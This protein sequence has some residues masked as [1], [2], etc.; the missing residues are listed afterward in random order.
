M[1]LPTERSTA[2]CVCEC[3]PSKPTTRLAE[4]LAFLRQAIRRIIGAPDYETYLARHR[5]IHPE[6]PPMS[7]KEFFRFAIDRRY[8]KAGPRCC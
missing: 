1:P 7:E 4:R 5:Q 3:A 2:P 6:V 8:A